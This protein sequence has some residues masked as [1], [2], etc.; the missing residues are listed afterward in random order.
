[1]NPAFHHFIL[2]LT[3]GLLNEVLSYFILKEGYSHAVNYNTY[4]LAEVLVICRQ[5]YLWWLLNGKRRLY[6]LILAV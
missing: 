6:Y 3:I 2:L 5:Y 1:M 4:S